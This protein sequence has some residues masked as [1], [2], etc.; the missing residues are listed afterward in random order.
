M[1]FNIGSGSGLLPDGTKLLPEPVLTCYLWTYVVLSRGKFHMNCSR[2]KLIEFENFAFKITPRGQLVNTL[3]PGQDGRHFGRQHFRL[4]FLEWNFFNFT[5]NFTEICYLDLIDNMSA[6]VQIMA[7]PRTGDKPLS[8]AMLL[9]CVDAYVSLSLNKLTH[10]GWVTHICVSKLTIIGSDNGLAP[11]RCQTIIWTNDGILLIGTLGTNFSEI[12]IKI[13]T[14]SLKKMY[15]KMS[16]GK[17]RPFCLGLNVLRRFHEIAAGPFW[18]WLINAWCFLLTLNSLAPR[19]SGW[20][21]KCVISKHVLLIDIFII[22]LC[23]CPQVSHGLHCPL[24]KTGC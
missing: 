22:S 4:H 20:N 12:L 13:N 5:Q 10:W 18:K 7:W 2:I 14:F 8:E 17:W 19:R 1:W 6:L 24:F 15:L 11:G 23:D 9:C 21:F 16:S 3:R